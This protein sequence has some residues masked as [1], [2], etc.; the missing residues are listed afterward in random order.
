[1][2]NNINKVTEQ[3]GKTAKW[4]MKSLFAA[5]LL[6][7]ASCESNLDTINENPNDQGQY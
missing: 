2:K 4:L 5:G 1:M 3:K 7:L 6:T